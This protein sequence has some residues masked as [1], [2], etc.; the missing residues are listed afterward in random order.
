MTTVVSEYILYI[1]FINLRIG[2][3]DRIGGKL[4]FES[5]A[6]LLLVTGTYLGVRYNGRKK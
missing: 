4:L 1:V 2:I 6:D 3:A 5:D